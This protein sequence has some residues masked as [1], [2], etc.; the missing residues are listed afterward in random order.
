MPHIAL[1]ALYTMYQTLGGEAELTEHL[2][3]VF[4]ALELVSQ[5]EYTHFLCP[6]KP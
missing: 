4:I 1:T 6:V 2:I 5:Y 3:S